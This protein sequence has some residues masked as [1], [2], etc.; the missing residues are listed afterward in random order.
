M[1]KKSLLILATVVALSA[2]MVISATTIYSLNFN[3][4]ANIAPSGTV[5][6]TIGSTDYTNGQ[7]LDINW[8]TVNVGA[9]NQ[10]ITIHNN[11]NTPVTPS[12][13]GT[14]LPSGWTLTLSDNSAI[15]AFGTTTI[16]I[17]LTV[18][19]NQA[20]GPY[21]WTAVLNVSS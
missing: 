15:S 9:N 14:G 5:T 4:N 3:M 8:T 10:A 11:V 1:R 19:S 6:I 12:I 21:S 16:N 13:V 2:I 17:V 20:A 18:P 7:T